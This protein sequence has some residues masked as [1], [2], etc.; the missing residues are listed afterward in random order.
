MTFTGFCEQDFDVFEVP[1]L[2]ARMEVL[3]RNVRPKLEAIGEQ[4]TP[5][6]TELCG[7]EMFPHIAKHARRTVNPPKDTWVAWAP[8]KRGYKAY[9]HFEVGMF[10]SHLFIVFAIIYESPNKTV[11]AQQLDKQL[12][13]IRS[14]LPGS[15][16]WSTDHMAPQ[17]ISHAEMQDEQFQTLIHKLANVKKSE[18]VCGLRLERNDPRLGDEKQLLELVQS[19]FKQLLP[20]YKMANQPE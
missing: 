19:T 5:F 3:I 10:S 6:M 11:F 8:S 20:L 7:E 9:P 14:H 16:Y 13:E 1:G 12:Q 4:L 18:V 2:E 15:Y 17:G